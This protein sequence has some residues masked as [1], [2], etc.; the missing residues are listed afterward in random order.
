MLTVGQPIWNHSRK[1]QFEVQEQYCRVFGYP[2]TYF[3]PHAQQICL[4]CS[5]VLFASV[6]LK[7]SGAAVINWA[8][9]CAEEWLWKW[10]QKCGSFRKS[11]ILVQDMN[12]YILW[13]VTWIGRRN[14][15]DCK[16]KLYMIKRWTSLVREMT[17]R[18]TSRVVMSLVGTT[19]I[20]PRIGHGSWSCGIPK[21]GLCCCIDI[22]HVHGCYYSSTLLLLCW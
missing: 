20:F 5:N 1:W 9:E 15:I 7:D 13:Y 4:N 6:F 14:G 11:S 10:I 3:V 22:T 19:F 17:R 18:E 21:R 12:Q 8:C 16:V 2:A